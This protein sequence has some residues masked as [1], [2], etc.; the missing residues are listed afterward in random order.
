ML[1]LASASPRRRELIK[2]VTTREVRI[3]PSHADENIGIK[4]PCVLAGQLALIKAKEVF[5]REGGTVIGADTVV[6]LGGRV[7]GK[8]IDEA[9]AREYLELLSERTHEVITGVAVVCRDKE[10]SATEVTRVTFGKLT[11]DFIEEYVASGSPMD[12]AGAYGLQDEMLSRFVTDV[13]GDRDNVVGLP[14]ELLKKIL[15]ENFDG[16]L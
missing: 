14:V 2:K 16:C 7:L 10:V 5:A 11:P 13:E 8:P 4:E 3:C 12:K 15:K 1:I 9:Q 6:A